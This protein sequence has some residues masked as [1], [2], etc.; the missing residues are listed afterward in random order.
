MEQPETDAA[1]HA[2]PLM[3]GALEGI[4]VLDLSR[5][6]AGPWATQ[7]LGDLGAEVIKIEKPG[8]G[9]DT[10]GWGP[11][12]VA[13]T[14][15]DGTQARGD[16]AYY[17][18]I[19]RNKKSVA[20]DMTVPEDLAV[21]KDLAREADV[22]VENFKV[23]GLKRYGLDY[24]GLKALKPDLIYC[25][26]TGFGQTGPYRER[27]GY[28]FLLQ[29]MSG[30]MSV[31]GDP[32]AEGGHPQKVGVA[33]ADI[34]TGMYAA[35][36]ILAALHHRSRTGEGQHID[37]GLLDVSLGV[38]ANQ[39]ANYLL[40]GINPQRMG[41]AHPNV[42]P[43]QDFQTKDG[44]VALAVGAD[45]QFARLCA[46]MELP[47]LAADARFITNAGRVEHRAALIPVLSARFKT[48]TS[49]E[50]VAALEAAA[51]PCG[52]INT[53]AEAFA[54]PQIQARGMHIAM[55]RTDTGALNLVANPLKMSA[56]PPRYRL[57]PPK[58]GADSEAVLKAL[59]TAKKA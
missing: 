43:Y 8:T 22:V 30:V 32:D 57:A 51:V 21:I 58:L 41:N 52:P 50:W 18:A 9:D 55:A 2:P 40:G 46:A 19:N 27:P 45:G 26:I 29:A 48:R 35:V 54:D 56:T 42:V 4:R 17:Y 11:P 38:L 16:A 20:L 25:S 14:G 7:I 5:I 10:R 49:A 53:I 36:G 39:N 24:N 6:L 59:G 12:F 3:P 13:E 33:I 47:E 31:T 28:D 1:R 23:G 44:Y 34:M 15:A 37:L